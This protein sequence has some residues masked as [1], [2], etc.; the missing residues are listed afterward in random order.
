[1]QQKAKPKTVLVVE[2]NE[3]S[4]RLFHALIESVGY[5]F[6]IGA[7]MAANVIAPAP[8]GKARLGS[9]VHIGATEFV[10]LPL[11]RYLA[12]S[13]ASLC[14]P[15]TGMAIYHLRLFDLHGVYV[16][17]HFVQFDDDGHAEAHANELLTRPRAGYVE[18]RR[19][20]RLI[21]GL[22]RNFGHRAR[23]TIR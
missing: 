16:I 5:S 23:T 10:W 13:A 18:I 4:M 19:D 12:R 9:H 22:E 7:T 3:I 14:R 6:I 20:G 2:D 8:A 11:S 17:G 1:M 21:C 15:A